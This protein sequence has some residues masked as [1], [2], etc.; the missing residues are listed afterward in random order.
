VRRRNDVEDPSARLGPGHF[1]TVV[2][3]AGEESHDRGQEH[4]ERRRAGNHQGGG[5]ATASRPLGLRLWKIGNQRLKL[6]VGPGGIERGQPL[7]QL[8]GEQPPFG[9]RS[10]Q[11]P[12]RRLAVCI[13]SPKQSPSLHHVR[14]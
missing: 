5:G 2:P 10:L 8:V 14:Q 12:C 13:R 6:L 9:R 11:P 4:G 3:Q 7:L 1:G